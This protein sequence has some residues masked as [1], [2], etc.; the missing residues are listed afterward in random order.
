MENTTLKTKTLVD[1]ELLNTLNAQ[2]CPACEGRFTL[3]DPVV[4]A[5]GAWGGGMKY[6]HESEAVFDRKSSCYVERSHY[7][8]MRKG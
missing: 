4:A 8:K 6:I 2:G 3:G 1:L 5:C 7:N